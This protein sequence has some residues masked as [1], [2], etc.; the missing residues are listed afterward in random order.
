MQETAKR[1]TS[2]LLLLYWDNL[3]N[4]LGWE[5]LGDSSQSSEFI[6]G[7][8]LTDSQFFLLIDSWYPSRDLPTTHWWIPCPWTPQLVHRSPYCSVCLIHTPR[9]PLS[10]PCLFPS[11]GFLGWQEWASRGSQQASKESEPDCVIVNL[12]GHCPR[13]NKRKLNASSLALQNWEKA[14][15]FKNSPKKEQEVWV[16]HIHRKGV[17]KPQNL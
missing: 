9:P 8:L 16:R 11:M 2:F 13:E 15:N 14:Y 1:P 3:Q 12:S 7:T 17:R 5:R 4:L 10:P 6:K